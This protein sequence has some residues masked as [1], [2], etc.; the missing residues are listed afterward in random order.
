[1]IIVSRCSINAE[2]LIEELEKLL[3]DTDVFIEKETLCYYF[4]SGR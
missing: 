4:Q 2:E 3:E 1:M